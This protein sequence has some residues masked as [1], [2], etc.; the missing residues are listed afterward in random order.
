MVEPL[1][2]AEQTTRSHEDTSRGAMTQGGRPR[3]TTIG[4]WALAAILLAGAAG[5]GFYLIPARQ[6]QGVS[7]SSPGDGPTAAPATPT[8]P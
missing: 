5:A 3:R 7:V 1:P 4:W 6:Q 8:R 2:D